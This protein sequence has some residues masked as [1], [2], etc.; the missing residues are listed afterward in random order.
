MTNAGPASCKVLD[1]WA[2][3]AWIRDEQPAGGKVRSLLEL[4]EARQVEL[5][6]NMINVGEVYYLLAKRQGRQWAAEALER[7]HT[8]PVRIVGASND[9]IQEA[10]EIKGRHPISYADA[11]AVATAIRHRATLVTGDP[12]LRPLADAGVVNLEWIGR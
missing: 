7:F 3:M 2:V 9:L 5:L 10:A 4:G 11:F 8:T 1:S 12:D 6:M